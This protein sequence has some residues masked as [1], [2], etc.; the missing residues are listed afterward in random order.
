MKTK[1]TTLLIGILITISSWSQTILSN[2]GFTSNDTV[3]CVPM[4]V[5][6][7]SNTPNAIAW[8]WNFGNGQ[9]SSLENPVEL[10]TTA[11]SYTITLTITHADG[12]TTQF[13][14]NNYIQVASQPEATIS[15]APYDAC[16]NTNNL[17]FQNNS[18]GATNYLWDFGDGNYSSD[19]SPNHHYSAAGNYTATL[20]AS[21]AQGCSANTSINMITIH[22]VAQN[23]FQLPTPVSTCN[24]GHTFSYNA[25]PSGL[26]SY[27]WT[28]STGST[29]SGQSI[30]H[31]FNAY[32]NFHLRLITVD[33]NGCV[34][35]TYKTN[36]AKVISPN[37]N[38]TANIT[39][40]CS[41]T[42]V[43]FQA[44]GS[45]A[46]APTVVWDFG[47]GQQGTGTPIQHAY[48]SS[49][50]YTVTM[51]A[52]N[53]AGCT[54]TIVKNN[55]ITIN[56]SP[57]AI[58]SI[59]DTN[60]CVNE[61]IHFEALSLN[62]ATVKWI[63]GD[64]STSTLP[65]VNHHYANSGVY[66]V[67][68]VLYNQ[69][70]KDTLT[71]TV[72][73]SQTIAQFQNTV[74]HNCAPAT[75]SFTDQSTSAVSWQWIFSNG[76]TSSDQNPTV[77]FTTPGNFNAQLIVTNSN[78]CSDTSFVSNAVTISNSI[79]SSYQYAEFN[80]CSPVAVSFY[81]YVIGT[82]SWNWNFGDGTTSNLPIPSHVYTTA[83]THVVSLTTMN[84]NGCAIYI[85]TFAVVNVNS[86]EIDSLILDLNCMTG[87]VEFNA[88]CPN[89]I[90]GNWNFGD[91]TGSSIT[92]TSHQYIEDELYFVSF[93]GVSAAGCVSYQTY[94][95]DVEN[96]T[97]IQ[98]PGG[99]LGGSPSA[100]MPGWSSNPNPPIVDTTA[101][102]QFCSPATINMINPVPN[103]QSW[104]WHYGDGAIG[105]GL[106]P[107]HT[108]DSVGMYSLM[109][110]Y[111]DGVTTDTLY[112]HNF[113]NIVGHENEI[114][115]NSVNTC[116]GLELSLTSQNTNLQNYFWSINN[117]PIMNNT[118]TLDTLLLSN[119]QLHSIT[120]TTHDET[121]VLIQLRLV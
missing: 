54:K 105:F 109:L 20:I 78:G 17:Q 55:Y 46:N 34:D 66:T 14:R 112:F 117:T 68:L 62:A 90:Q 88:M 53:S 61:T 50:Q 57:F 1:F 104:V 8:H 18:V 31:T 91:G 101:V 119:N 51:T 86:L 32:G 67:K 121:C 40:T 21:N 71:K 97:I 84:G 33:N 36:V 27:D 106:E 58:L 5:N 7:Q 65:S 19:F 103:G 24:T 29:Y 63:F 87:V 99:Q 43:T 116:D 38:F 85:D 74:Q 72:N 25:T 49:G 115:I 39:S 22:P 52:T 41:L 94:S 30:Q 82:G 10:F 56:N 80:G 93:N 69:G 70:C 113:V 100:T 4:V 26:V 79:P 107:F 48:A 11:G 73:V 92:S 16:L 120:L 64:G 2:A 114:V 3:G 37:H 42:D 77:T 13:I 108:Y 44:T 83:G 110:E 15:I 111:F 89:C 95:V 47:D 12:S 59:S 75:V 6:F 118:A 60:A 45:A 98:I 23:N 28:F 96:C 35:T 9:L 102:F 76:V 81:N